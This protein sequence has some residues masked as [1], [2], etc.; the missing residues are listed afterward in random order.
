MSQPDVKQGDILIVDDTL[1]N[2][3]YLQNLLTER[4]YE[5]RGVPS[6][7]MALMVAHNEPPDLILLDIRMPDLDGYDVCRQLKADPKTCDIPV[8][9]ISAMDAVLD[10]V[11]AF[12]VGGVDY[13]T[14][15]FQIDEIIARVENHLTIRLLQRQL[16]E[17]NR[18]LSTANDDLRHANRSLQASTEE[19]DA[20]ARTMAFDLKNPFA[21]IIGYAELLRETLQDEN[22]PNVEDMELL[23][24]IMRSGRQGI[25]IIDALLLLARVRQDAVETGA[26]DMA[27]VFHDVLRRLKRMKED[28]QA[29]LT[30]PDQWPL[31][32][33]YGPWL[34]EVWINYVSNA[35]KYGG[36]PPHVVLGATPMADNTIRF[37]VRDNGPG[38]AAE[39][40]DNLFTHFT[41]LDKVG[42]GHGLGLAIVRRIIEKLGGEVG[43]ESNAGQ[44][45]LFYFTL[46]AFRFD[47]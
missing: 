15:P 24:Q 23:E 40:Q 29:E 38:V 41:R 13:I 32:I 7:R 3:R 14:K 8:I 18:N 45:S 25:R 4:G 1:P 5:V 28:S 10:K 47:G 46:P 22:T 39:V 36:Q 19:L 17:A 21:A 34:E 44:G 27:V 20:F 31:A 2:L 16:Q 37:W 30:M 9:F 43:V 35:I 12:D 11:K 42:Q 6:G 33:G 26:I